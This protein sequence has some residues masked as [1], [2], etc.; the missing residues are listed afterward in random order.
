MVSVAEATPETARATP[1]LGEPTK[2]LAPSFS[3]ASRARLTPVSG[4]LAV[5]LMTTSMGCPATMFVPLVAY[6]RPRAKPFSS[7]GP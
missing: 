3:M 5:S 1:E 6:S 7:M 2:I 4:V